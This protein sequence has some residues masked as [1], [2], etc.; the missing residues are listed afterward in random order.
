MLDLWNVATGT[1]LKTIIDQAQDENIARNA[2][3]INRL[4]K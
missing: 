2:E 3:E 4:K 1:K